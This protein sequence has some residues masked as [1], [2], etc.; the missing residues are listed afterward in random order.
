MMQTPAFQLLHP[1][2]QQ[3]MSD[4][5]WGGLYPV[6]EEAIRC[7]AANG[8]DLIVS[9][10][11]SGGKT[12]AVFLPILSELVGKPATTVQVLCISPLKALI[13]DQ[14][15]RLLTM[16]QPLGIGV[17]RWH[18]DVDVEAKRRLREHPSG[19]LFITP[20]SV[21]STFINYPHAIPKLYR[22]LRC[23]VV[24][25]L[26]VLLETERGMHVRSLVAR[27][28]AAIERRPRCFDLSATLGDPFAARSFLN[29]DHP[30]S[31][32]VISDKSTARPISVEVVSITDDSPPEPNAGTSATDKH[33][34]K[35]GTLAIIAEDLRSVFSDGS[36]LVFGNSRRT[37]EEL[38]D[39]FLGDCQMPV[40][41]E[42]VVA[43]HHGSLSARLRRRTEAMLKS[44]TPTLALCTSSLELG[45]DIGAVEA[46]AQ[47]DPPWS[48]AAMVQRLGRSGRKPGSTSNLLLYLRIGSAQTD[49]S[50]TDLLYPAL[51]QATAMVKLLLGGWLE[52]IRPDR[53]HLSTLVHQTLSVLK[54]TGGRTA[55]ALYQSL[56][57]Q[58]P[59]RRVAPGDFVLLLRGLHEHDLIR[60]DAEG[61][62]F[63]GMAGER[64]TSAPGFY[65]AFST[66]VEL[67]VRWGAKELGRL[68][69]SAALKEGECLLL[70]GRRWMVDS[71]AWKSKCVWVSPAAIKKAPVFFGGV[72]ETHD[73]V[74]QEMRRVLLGDEEPDC[75]D[76]NSLELLRSAR[77]VARKTG[78]IESDLLDLDDG[79]QWFPWVGTRSMRTLQLWAK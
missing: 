67:T 59:F 42:P 57:R 65:A 6:Q 39:H 54:E 17:H 35:C 16:C 50:L 64:V 55:L 72:G 74:F 5:G 14:Y 37:V 20:E 32:R 40:A 19:I 73:R 45:I 11:T 27:L 2:V 60:Q 70:N 12:E 9:A 15:G 58:G 62:L 41:G 29:Q 43:L 69:A 77:D 28:M 30:D 3:V 47:I 1:R 23:L 75:L 7:F 4:L 79:L 26:H 76:A 53:M 49:T 10:P 38:A 61:I 78:L 18:G 24:D 21:E 63:L 34:G 13:N 31:V 36:Y 66:P 33:N 25:E 22:D 52:P 71:I 46:V 51:L 8:F 68:P 44:G 48:V 56:C